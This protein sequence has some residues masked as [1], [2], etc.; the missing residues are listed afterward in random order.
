LLYRLRG[1]R[2]VGLGRAQRQKQAG[3]Q[4]GTR[5]GLPVRVLLVDDV[6]TTGSTLAACAVELRSS[7]VE[8]VFAAVIAQD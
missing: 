2:Q 1:D 3:Q 7:G 5:G 8:Q 4:Y 6:V